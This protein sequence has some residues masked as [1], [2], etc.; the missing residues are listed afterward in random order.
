MILSARNAEIIKRANK[1]TTLL[2]KLDDE[3]NTALEQLCSGQGRD[4]E[5]LTTQLLR[6]YVN[7][8]QLRQTLQD[9]ELAKLY[10]ELQEEDRALANQGM[11]D[12]QRILHEADLS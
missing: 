12:Y 6:Q 7:M 5:S 2:I 3:L 9:P 4:K 10:Q 11:A 1:M 8:E